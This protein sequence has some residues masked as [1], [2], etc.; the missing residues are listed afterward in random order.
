MKYIASESPKPII[1]DLYP[2]RYIKAI[3]QLPKDH[4]SKLK[5]PIHI[6]LQ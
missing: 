5:T 6:S 2:I 1:C 4:F 3:Y